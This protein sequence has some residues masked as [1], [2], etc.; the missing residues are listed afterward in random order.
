MTIYVGTDGS[1][2]AAAALRWAAREGELRNLPVTAVV[3]WDF[4]NQARP[5]GIDEFDPTYSEEDALAVLHEWVVSAV[6]P[7]RASTIG[8]IS[9][10]DLPWRALVETSRE[11]DLLVVG[12]RGSGGFLGLRIGSERAR[13]GRR[14]ARS[15]WSMTMRAGEAVTEGSSSGS[16]DRDCDNALTRALDEPGTKRSPHVRVAPTMAY[17]GDGRCRH[18]Q[19][20]ADGSFGRRAP[21]R[22]WADPSH[23]TWWQPAGGV[24]AHRRCS[25]ATLVVVGS[26]PRPAPRARLRSVSA[27]VHPQMPVVVI[28]LSPEMGHEQRR[29]AHAEEC[30][31]LLGRARS[32][33]F[34]CSEAARSPRAIPPCR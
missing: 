13:C 30:L 5:S 25:R 21:F 4:L 31:R 28:R 3:A 8:R 10:C 17:R 34:R 19:K 27:V 1:A 2:G 32:V 24:S 6:G 7:E 14:V 22:T 12:A 9:V 18:F 23:P 11:A 33:A 16:T 26:R 20:A 29:D 15:R